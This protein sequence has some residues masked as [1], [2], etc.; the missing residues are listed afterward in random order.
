ML[1]ILPNNI[2]P[3]TKHLPLSR[4]RSPPNEVTLINTCHHTWVA[5]NLTRPPLTD[6]IRFS[7]YTPILLH[8]PQVL[9][10]EPTLTR[11][12]ERKDDA[13]TPTVDASSKILKHIC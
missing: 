12:A 7:P 5:I 11:K 10:R 2:S 13:Q 4:L 6:E 9:D 8:I 1:R 3:S